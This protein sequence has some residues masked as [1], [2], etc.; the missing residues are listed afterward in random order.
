[1][2]LANSAA[3]VVSN[4]ETGS[5]FDGDV[6]GAAENDVGY[7]REASVVKS[8]YDEYDD[9]QLD[10]M[11]QAQM[12][13][14]RHHPSENRTGRDVTVP[15]SSETPPFSPPPLT[16]SYERRLRHLAGACSEHGRHGNGMKTGNASA[17]D[18]DAVGD[19]LF[20]ND[21]LR[22]VYCLVPKVACTT[23]SRVLLIAAG[24]NQGRLPNSIPQ[25]V[26]NAERL[27]DNTLKK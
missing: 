7:D 1:M 3:A 21:K 23:W 26:V 24:K 16:S 13:G 8:Y 18:L 9:R 10:L 11:R 2:P 17:V 4:G 22:F 19:N 27:E 20:V 12:D 6:E 25:S 5:D 14:G 15:S